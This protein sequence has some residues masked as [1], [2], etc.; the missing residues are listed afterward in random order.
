MTDAQRAYAE[1]VLLGFQRK[2]VRAILD[3]GDDTLS[4]KIALAHA[5][6][7][8]LVAVIGRRE[9]ERR[10]VAIREREG[11]QQRELP[12]DEAVVEVAQRCAPL[13]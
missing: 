6:A 13:A 10:S 2:G 1:E 5:A 12:L 11:G 3:A 7:I 9:A 8:P 4:R